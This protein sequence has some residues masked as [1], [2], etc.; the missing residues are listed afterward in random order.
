MRHAQMLICL[1]IASSL[2]LRPAAGDTAKSQ[3]SRPPSFREFDRRP[4]T[5]SDAEFQD[6]RGHIMSR[7]NVAPGADPTK[8]PWYFHYELGLEL[9][10]RGDPQRALDALIEA[11]NHRPDP[12]R[13]ARMYGMWFTQY[14]PYFEI[15]KMHLALGNRRC[16]ADALRISTGRWEV[17]E[18]DRE[19]LDLQ[20]LKA[21]LEA[22][23]DQP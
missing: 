7:C 10:R 21:A 11:T 23:P 2:E 19:Y 13:N 1:L 20:E 4:S 22:H 9:E 8:A 5:L 6:L 14:R 18:G 3:P 17:T 15:A 16:A 12:R